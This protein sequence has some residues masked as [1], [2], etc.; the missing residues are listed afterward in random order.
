M[1]HIL[2]RGNRGLLAQF[3]WSKV[4]LGFDFDGTLAPIVSQ[5]DKAGLRAQTRTL[6]R[7]VAGCYPCV[8]ISGRSVA[9][10]TQRI[11]GLGV[12]EVVGN[13]GGEPS[14]SSGLL[15]QEVAA[16][17][18]TLEAKLA[19]FRGVTIENKGLSVAIHYRA[20]REK[21]KARAAIKAAAGLLGAVRVIGGKQVVNI[22]PEG[23][24]HK[25]T[26]LERARA[27]HGCDTAI[28]I[29]DDDTDEDV[30]TLDQPG[31][32]VSIRIGA[33]R[34]TAADYCLKDQAEIDDLLKELL[35]L[36]KAGVRR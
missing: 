18:P 1:K 24:P 6:L 15:R 33:K 35:R 22:L 32:L 19:A 2:S 11:R 14:T 31:Q 12:L 3:A 21:K 7:Q 16:W 5:P 13:H 36:R 30:F 9:D 17:Q 34:T 4:L 25:G 27:A 28:F 23:A 10:V 20:C 8:V 26:A 29:G